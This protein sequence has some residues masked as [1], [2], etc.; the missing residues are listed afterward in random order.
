MHLILQ[1]I[2][3]VSSGAQE[4]SCVVYLTEQG[5]GEARHHAYHIKR[6]LTGHPSLKVGILEG[7][8]ALEAAFQRRH[9]LLGKIYEYARVALRGGVVEVPVHLQGSPTRDNALSLSQAS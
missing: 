4:S 8:E 6:K 3:V 7:E 1:H 9:D 5:D 2:E